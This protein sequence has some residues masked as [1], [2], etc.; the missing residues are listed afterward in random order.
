LK[1]GEVMAAKKWSRFAL[2]RRL[3]IRRTRPAEVAVH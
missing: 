2:G 1:K 3:L